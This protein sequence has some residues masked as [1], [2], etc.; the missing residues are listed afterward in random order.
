MAQHALFRVVRRYQRVY[1]SIL[2]ML[3]GAHNTLYTWVSKSL[4]GFFITA[5]SNPM[6]TSLCTSSGGKEFAT[7]WSSSVHKQLDRTP[8]KKMELAPNVSDLL[9]LQNSERRL[10]YHNHKAHTKFVITKVNRQCEGGL[11]L[12]QTPKASHSSSATNRKRGLATLPCALC[13]NTIGNSDNLEGMFKLFKLHVNGILL[14]WCH[15]I[16]HNT[17]TRMFNYRHK[18]VQCILWYL[19]R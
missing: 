3:H 11:L 5:S 18:K 14:T 9:F 2:C 17:Y 10:S 1:P 4:V 6:I 12:S 16:F 19:H 13:E 15:N 8:K 7:T